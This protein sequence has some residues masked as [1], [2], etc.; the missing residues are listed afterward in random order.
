MNIKRTTH[1]EIPD[2]KPLDV[3]LTRTT[4]M[5]I[6]AHQD[7]L[8]I[9]AY[10]AIST[11]YKSKKKCFFGVVVTDGAKSARQGRFEHLTDEEMK[12]IRKKEQIDA[13]HLGKYGA[14]AMLGYP[15]ESMKKDPY[16]AILEIK[17]LIERSKPDVI[18]THNLADKH[19]THIA[20]A[21]LVIKAIR[22]LKIKDRPKMLYGV[23][24][25]RSLDWLDDYDKIKLDTSKY[26]HLAK[27]LIQIFASQVDGGKRYDQATL[28]RRYANATFLSPHEVDQLSSV[29]YAMDLTPLIQDDSLD[30]KTFINQKVDKFRQD[31][32]ERMDRFK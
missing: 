14:L 13:A 26:P 21:N 30:L 17:D 29:Q 16:E 5:A 3:A 8:E 24:V 2:N 1:Y 28:G 23:E 19:D 27:K 4:H 12:E 6:V 10:D 11:C 25:W 9:M 7:D 18:Y 15:S 31:V 22:L 20:V 32:N